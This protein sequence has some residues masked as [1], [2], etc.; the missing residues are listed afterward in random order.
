MKKGLA[1]LSLALF[2][3]QALYAQAVTTVTGK[4]LYEHH[5]PMKGGQGNVDGS[6]SGYDFMN[7]AYVNSFNPSTF[8]PHTDGTDSL[9]DMVEH[10]GPYGNGDNFGFTSGVSSIWNGDI[11][12]NGTT[13]WAMGS[14]VFNYNMVNTVQQIAA[15]YSAANASVSIDSVVEG[16]TYVGRIRNTNMY[17]AMRTYNVTNDVNDNTYFDFD[18]KYGILTTSVDDL[19][20]ANA[21]GMYPN[22]AGTSLTV[23]NTL[24]EQI[25]ASIV[26]VTGQ[27]LQQFSLGKN[28]SKSVNVSELAGGLY[29]IVYTTQN[30]SR[31]TQRFV[32]Q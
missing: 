7:H 32:K 25:A 26:S 9:I 21:L 27:Q 13:M 16:G 8:G 12:G 20:K 18:Y 19:S 23:M 1:L 24:D 4:R 14:L 5:S 29:M 22:P 15:E 3:A 6:Q 28:G 30:G 11:Q 17:V 2:A 31:H 10:N